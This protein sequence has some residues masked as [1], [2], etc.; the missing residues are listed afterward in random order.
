MAENV[1][2]NIAHRGA[3]GIYPELTAKAFHEAIVQGADYIETDITITK[4]DVLVC[5]HQPW[6]HLTTNI[7]KHT[8]FM[9]KRS[10]YD[11]PTRW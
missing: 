4:D 5:L 2:L 10:T 11:F 6:L 3:C 8:E 7:G 9:N 1:P